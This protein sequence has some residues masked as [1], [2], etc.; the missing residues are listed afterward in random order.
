MMYPND[1]S[2][3]L[4]GSALDRKINDVDMPKIREDTYQ[5]LA[6]LR[7]FMEKEKLDI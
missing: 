2:S 1:S 4:V 5:R 6:D 3:T 7:A